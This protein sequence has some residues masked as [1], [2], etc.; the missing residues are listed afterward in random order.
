MKNLDLVVRV[1]LGLVFILFGF[2]KFYAFMPTPPMT[3]SAANF[4]AAIITTGYMWNLIG[5]LE[6]I[7]GFLVLF[8]R[9]SVIG[10]MILSPIIINIIA[11]LIFLQHSIGA[12]PILMVLFLLTS[13]L[14]LA[15]RRWD[16]WK[17]VI[18]EQ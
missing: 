15:Y 9:S 18:F 1:L 10:L 6:I 2:S 17:S 14:F 12:P 13:S 11:Y 8:H 3:P 5:I 7:G 4:I 16:R